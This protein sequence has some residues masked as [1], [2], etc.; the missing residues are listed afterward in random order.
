MTFAQLLFNFAWG[1][2]TLI[3]FIYMLLL[4][5]W[6]VGAYPFHRAFK[7]DSIPVKTLQIPAAVCPRCGFKSTEFLA[8]AKKLQDEEHTLDDG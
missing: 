8:L 5:N 1:H 4:A 2:L 6:F 3:G 7:D